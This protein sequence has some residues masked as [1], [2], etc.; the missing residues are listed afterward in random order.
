MEHVLPEQPSPEHFVQ[1][2]D[3]DVDNEVKLQLE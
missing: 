1:L 2:I 3:D